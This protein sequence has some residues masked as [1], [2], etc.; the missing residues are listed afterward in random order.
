MKK[1]LLILFIFTFC[2]QVIVAQKE[3]TVLTLKNSNDGPTI[4]K[5]IY[6]HFAEHLG[7]C[8]YG[9]FFVG[10]KSSIPNTKGVRNDIITAL[11]EL[12]IPNLRWPGGC[13]ADTYHWKDGIGPKEDRPSIVNRWWGGT[14]EDNSFGTHDF[15]NLCEVLGTEPYLASNVGSGTVQELEQWVQYVNHDSGSPMSE[16]RKKND[17]EK[18]W[19]VTFWGVG[20]EMWGCGG[21]MTP[22]YYANLYKQYATF[23]TDWSNN[24]KLFRI[25]SGAN[26]A[27]YHWTEVLMRDIPKSLIEGVALHSYSFVKWEKKGSSTKFNEEQYF[28]T[29]QTALKMEELVTKHSDIMDKYDPENKV[30]LIVDEWGGWYD[31]EE[32]TNP[33]FLYQQNTM[34]DAMIAGTTLNIFNNHSKRVKMANLAQTVN[35]LQAVILTENEKMLL[36]PTYHVMK[37]YTVHHDAQLLPMTIN[38]PSYTHNGEKLPAL[39]AS[40]SK[41]KNGLIHI[42]LVNIDSKKDHKI[43][44][45]MQELGIKNVTG[46]ILASPKLQDHNTFDNPSKIKPAVF[47]GFETKKGKLEITIPAFTVVVLETK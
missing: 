5:H 4:S 38:S 19:G 25:A 36:T 44:I 12:K 39:S 3:T 16:L 13:F 17:R 27:D 29:M 46:T 28:A 34:R 2:T 26:V 42:S 7:K 33:G 8:I 20:N 23:M 47:K 30:A 6:G 32:G 18:P 15:L 14:T 10:E 35:V 24:D 22:E 9:G 37:M 45:D 43:E 40:A 1:I 11:K 31:V 41:D 21:N